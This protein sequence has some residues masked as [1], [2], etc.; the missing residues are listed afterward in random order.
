[1]GLH[2]GPTNVKICL[3]LYSTTQQQTWLH[4]IFLTSGV[5]ITSPHFARCFFQTWWRRKNKTGSICTTWKLEPSPCILLLNLGSKFRFLLT[6]QKISGFRRGK[7]DIF[8][9][10]SQDV[11]RQGRRFRGGAGACAPHQGAGAGADLGPSG[12]LGRPQRERERWREVE[13]AER[14]REGERGR[15]CLVLALTDLHSN[16][17]LRSSQSARFTAKKCWY[18]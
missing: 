10:A 12:G 1:M 7:P 11:Q 17:N 8:V 4:S 13:R 9:G 3:I 6:G 2:Y 18:S 5:L 15:M 16:L 14:E